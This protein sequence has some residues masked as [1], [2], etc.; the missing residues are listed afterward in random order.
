MQACKLE[1]Q[2]ARHLASETDNEQHR[3][4]ERQ[5]EEYPK[6]RDS[7]NVYKEANDLLQQQLAS[8]REEAS[9]AVAS[10]NELAIR[11]ADL[12]Q[13]LAFARHE[14]HKA[15]EVVRCCSSWCAEGFPCAILSLAHYSVPV[16]H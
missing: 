5:N 9:Q 3:E 10:A 12:E 13:Q 8:S 6:L 15:A 7:L 2:Q 14:A 1:L 11:A 16:V 4:R